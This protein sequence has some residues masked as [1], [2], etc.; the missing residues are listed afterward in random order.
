M[1][2]NDKQIE[3]AFHQLGLAFE[4]AVQV[5]GPSCHVAAYRF[6]GL[7]VR[8]RILGDALAAGVSGPFAHLLSPDGPSDSAALAVDLWSADSVRVPVPG[9]LDPERGPDEV[10]HASRSGRFLGHAMGGTVLW[11]DRAAGHLVGW[12]QDVHGQS[13]RQR[14][15]PLYLSLSVWYGDRGLQVIHAGLVATEGMGT[16]LA[17]ASGVGKSTVALACVQAGFDFLGDDRVVLQTAECAGGVC[18]GHSMYSSCLL[19]P[20]HLARFPSVTAHA[21]E[22]LPTDHPKSVLLLSAIRRLRV[23]AHVPV[24]VVLLPRIGN[25]KES[26]ARLCPESEALLRIA[27]NSLRAFPNAGHTQLRRLAQL[28]RTTP[29]YDLELG[30]EIAGIP[31]SVS[32]ILRSVEAP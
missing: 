32:E 22:G 14:A 23:A 16:L 29:C 7:P 21:L 4:R 26:G 5:H 31:R 12:V 2:L 28:V 3:A 27:P 15:R 30:S 18:E 17:G 19:H 20:H 24:R 11:L 25:G 9:L 8:F 13:K 1:P 10:V 6:A